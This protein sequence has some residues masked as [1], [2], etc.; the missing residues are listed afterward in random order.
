MRIAKSADFGTVIVK[1]MPSGLNSLVSAMVPSHLS[2][3]RGGFRAFLV[4]S[5]GKNVGY[6]ENVDA[7]VDI[8][9]RF[10]EIPI[11]DDPDGNA[12][13]VQERLGQE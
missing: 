1:S 13:T 11:L 10:P 12:W 4:Q 3:I 5:Y 6:K 7:L 8:Y 2:A 9:G